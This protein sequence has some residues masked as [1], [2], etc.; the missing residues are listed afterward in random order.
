MDDISRRTFVNTFVIRIWYESSLDATRWRGRIEH[1][2]SGKHAA[3]ID[4]ERIPAFIGSLIAFGGKPGDAD[5]ESA[6]E[7]QES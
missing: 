3:F 1:L 4:L 6:E 7:H 2:P 5:G